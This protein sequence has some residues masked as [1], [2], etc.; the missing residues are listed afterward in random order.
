MHT[1]PWVL[2]FRWSILYRSSPSTRASQRSPPPPPRPARISYFKPNQISY[3][4]PDQLFQTCQ[5]SLVQ[6]AAPA[7]RDK[8]AISFAACPTPALVRWETTDHSKNFGVAIRKCHPVQISHSQNGCAHCPRHGDRRRGHPQHTGDPAP[9]NHSSVGTPINKM[10][11]PKKEPHG[12]PATASPVSPAWR[13]GL[14]LDIN[15]QTSWKGSS[16]GKNGAAASPMLLRI[17]LNVRNAVALNNQTLLPR[18]GNCHLRLMLP[19]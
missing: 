14:T 9:Q 6:L 7:K 4:K 16:L 12:I 10:A 3:F 13:G 1:H 18:L 8:T 2:R 15:T 5:L 11:N 19:F 17:I